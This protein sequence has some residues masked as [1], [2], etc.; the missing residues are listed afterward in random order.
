[1]SVSANRLLVAFRGTASRVEAAFH[2][3]LERV[4]LAGGAIGRSTT[5][6]VRLPGSVARYVQSVVGLDDL[7]PLTNG[8]ERDN[9]PARHVP[10]AALAHL[11]RAARGVTTTPVACSSALALQAEFGALTDTQI[12][13][14]YGVEG[15]YHSGDLGSGQ[16]VDIYELEPFSMSDIAAFDTCYFGESHTS[17]ITVTAVDGGPGT[18]PGSGEAALDIEDVSAI[19]PDADIHVFEAPNVGPDADAPF[20]SLDIWNAIATADDAHQVS[21][22]WGA[23]RDRVPAEPAGRASGRERPLRAD[24]R[25]GAV[26]LLGCRR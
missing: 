3:G 2:T 5:A 13:T 8:L 7:V 11:T 1:V 24:G 9:V 14:S 26:H 25:P 6:S 10:A 17:Q 21:T 16:T 20:S 23:V 19:A 4:R 12:A 18:G 15:L 22:S